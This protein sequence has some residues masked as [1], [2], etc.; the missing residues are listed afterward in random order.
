MPSF[1]ITSATDLRDSSC[2]KANANCS[3]KKF[4]F[5][6]SKTTFSGHTSVKNLS[7]QS[8]QEMGT[9]LIDVARSVM[10][11]PTFRG[12]LMANDMPLTRAG[13]FHKPEQPRWSAVAG[14]L[15]IWQFNTAW[16][17]SEAAPVVPADSQAASL[18]SRMFGLKVS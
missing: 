1:R 6:Y 18:L 2:L 11:R 16:Q 8:D 9:T 17:F 12:E 10:L 13:C 4:F 3:S 5:S 15:V 7:F 14:G